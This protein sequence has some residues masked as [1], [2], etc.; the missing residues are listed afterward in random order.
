MGLYIDIACLVALIIAALFVAYL[1]R[2]K[3][4]KTVNPVPEE[5][6]LFR[7][8]QQK[9]GKYEEECRRIFQ[10]LFGVPFKKC[11]PDFLKNP[12]TG[13]NLEL[14][15]FNANVRTP[16]G[17]GL[18]FEYNGEQH[19][20]FTRKFHRKQ[21]DFVYQCRKDSWKNIRCKRLNI[22]LINIPSYVTFD[23][24][25]KYIINELAAEKIFPVMRIPGR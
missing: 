16:I 17:K 22:V 6:L 21:E 5:G 2:N 7:P 15:G 25:E 23:H 20:K 1:N 18:G 14:D 3:P 9:Y 10:R 4:R 8:Q 12:A 11:R 24:L 13:K 19:E